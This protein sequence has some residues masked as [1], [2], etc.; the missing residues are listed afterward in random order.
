MLRVWARGGREGEACNLF[1]EEGDGG[2]LGGWG[3][4]EGC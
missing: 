1:W 3:C 2:M 4:V